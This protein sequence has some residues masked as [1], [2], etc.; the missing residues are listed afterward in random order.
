[1]RYPEGSLNFSCF[2]VFLESVNNI[3]KHAVHTI[4]ETILT[5]IFEYLL[6]SR[7]TLYTFVLQFGS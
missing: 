5:T 4:H 7:P 2:A 3:E 1:M 6:R